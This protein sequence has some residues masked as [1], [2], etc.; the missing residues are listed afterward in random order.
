MHLWTVFSA[1]AFFLDLLG[2]EAV[3][4]SLCSSVISNASPAVCHSVNP[5]KQ[6]KVVGKDYIGMA[7]KT[8]GNG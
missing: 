5:G 3:K 8:A 7:R 6:S 2:G 1:A 4:A